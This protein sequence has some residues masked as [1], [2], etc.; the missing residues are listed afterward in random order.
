LDEDVR[1]SKSY[2]LILP[3]GYA[4]AVGPIHTVSGFNI[5]GLIKSFHIGSG[6][7]YPK[8]FRRMR[9]IINSE[10]QALGSGFNTPNLSKGQEETLFS[11]QT[12][13]LF[14]FL[15]LL[16]LFKCLKSNG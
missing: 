12:I 5:E 10:T 6:S 3:N 15:C 7:F 8:F 9:I 13:N 11:S 1:S 4:Q 14:T 16:C 2:I